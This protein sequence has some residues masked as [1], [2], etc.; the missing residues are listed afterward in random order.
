M[1]LP[2]S[3]TES[4]SVPTDDQVFKAL[5]EIREASHTLG[6]SKILSRLRSENNWTLSDARLKRFINYQ[7]AARHIHSQEEEPTTTTAVTATA[8]PTPTP[9]PA[10]PQQYEPFDMELVAAL[11]CL[12]MTDPGVS[13][14]KVLARLQTEY[15]WNLSDKR[16]KKCMTTR[17]G[18][19]SSLPA[20]SA[21]KPQTKPELVF[22]DNSGRTRRLENQVHLS[23]VSMLTKLFNSV[24]KLYEE[25][26]KECR[27]RIPPAVDSSS[28]V[29]ETAAQ[30]IDSADG[31]D[32]A[33]DDSFPPPT[34][35]ADPYAAQMDY[36]Q[37]SRRTIILY[38][39]GKWN[40]G[41]TPNVDMGL[42]IKITHDRIAKDLREN[43]PRTPEEKLKFACYPGIMTLWELYEVAAR[44]AA[45]SRVD[46]GKQFEAEFG[47]DMSL[48]LPDRQNSSKSDE[49]LELRNWENRRRE[50]WREGKLPIL[51]VMNIERPWED[52]VHGQFALIVTR[53]DKNTGEECGD[54]S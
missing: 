40:Y 47:V 33:T 49:N 8:A 18:D 39:R 30:G 3:T 38:G 5:N 44:K 35:P 37:N 6:R 1:T 36:A 4:P 29:P 23:P 9:A 50:V 22:V 20:V 43:K 42:Y 52:H 26:P 41:V 28:A 19:P 54:L 10:P 34:L 11:E 24:D 53:L 32:H 14:P 16:L 15:R 51:R 31:N 48:Y 12:R 7:E 21:T 46:I 27:P 13:R 2:L 25:F 45:I 17:Y